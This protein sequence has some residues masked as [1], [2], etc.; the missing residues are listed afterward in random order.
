[1]AF[2]VC[3]VCD[4]AFRFAKL[5]ADQFYNVD[6]FHFVMAAY[7]VDFSYPSLVDDQVDGTAMILYIQPVTDIFSFS[8]YRKLSL[9]HI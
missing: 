4:Q 9:I 2:T 8:I 6:V 1:M 3:H 5:L 7:I